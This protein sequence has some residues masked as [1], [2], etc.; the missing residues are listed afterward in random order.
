MRKIVY[1]VEPG[2]DRTQLEATTY[3]MRNFYVQM[4][5]GFFSVLDIMNYIQHHSIVLMAKAGDHV[6]DVCCGRGLLLPLMRYERK[7]IASY[8]GVDIEPKNAVWRHQRVT[9][10]KPI[11]PN[12]YPFETN[13]VQSNASKMASKLIPNHYD[14]VVY[15]SSIEHMQKETGMESLHEIRKVIAP[16]GRMILTCPNTPEDK[17]GY[18]T[19]YAAHIY[20]WKRSELIKGFEESGF[21]IKRE[22]TILAGKNDIKSHYPELVTQLDGLIPNPWLIAVLSP[23]VPTNYAKEIAFIL[24]PKS[25]KRQN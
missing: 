4:K 11:E 18:D 8:T 19:Q 12:Y 20:E 15:T 17:H 21:S 23:L 3:Q 1:K 7:N 14:L 5:D 10:G 16:N 2:M 25:P 24:K 6:L 13:F 9:D 22:Y